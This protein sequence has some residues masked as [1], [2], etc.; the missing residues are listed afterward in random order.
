LFA[1]RRGK[2]KSLTTRQ[3]ARLVS[4]WTAMIAWTQACSGRIP[5]AVQRR[6]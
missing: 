2:E 4:N 5:C 1:G 6:H 3:Y